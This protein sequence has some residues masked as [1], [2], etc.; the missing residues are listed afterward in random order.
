M[1]QYRIPTLQTDKTLLTDLGH[2]L[3]QRRITAELTQKALAN[4]AGL[5]KRTVERLERGE[6]VQL[7]SFLRVLRVLGALPELAALMPRTNPAPMDLL[8]TK[9]RE[10]KRVSSRRPPS[11]VVGEKKWTWGEPT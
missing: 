3:A 11:G 6:S 9:S 1:A 7:A 10:R 5:G 4:Q 8:K 2:G